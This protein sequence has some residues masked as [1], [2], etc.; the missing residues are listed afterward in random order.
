MK[1]HIHPLPGKEREVYMDYENPDGLEKVIKESKK[2]LA[3]NPGD[4]YLHKEV[5]KIK[6]I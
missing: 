2:R 6:A 1:Y 3:E 5:E 4:V